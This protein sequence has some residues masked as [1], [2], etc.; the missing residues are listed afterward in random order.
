[1]AASAQCTQH[2]WQLLELVVNEASRKHLN[3]SWCRC[4]DWILQLALG[5]CQRAGRWAAQVRVS[6]RVICKLT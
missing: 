2:N 1:M 4:V 6:V 3:N 5:M